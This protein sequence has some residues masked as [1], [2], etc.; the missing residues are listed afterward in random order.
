LTPIK[1]LSFLSLYGTAIPFLVGLFLYKKF[2]PTFKK[3]FYYALAATVFEALAKLASINYYPN[4]FIYSAF[5][6]VE[7]VLISYIFYP[8]LATKKTNVL[9]IVLY[10]IYGITYLWCRLFATGIFVRAYSQ[11]LAA[12][13]CLMFFAGFTAHKLAEQLNERLIKNSLFLFAFTVLFFNATNMFVYATRIA[14]TMEEFNSIYTYVWGFHS[15]INF[16]FHLFITLAMWFNSQQ[17]R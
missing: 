8:V 2:D 14:L 11:T 15:I 3:V 10:T 4:T 16:L 7:I 9:Y 13:F 17:K 12:S 5:S 1:I 6:V